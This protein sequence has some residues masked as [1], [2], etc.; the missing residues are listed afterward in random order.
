M[1]ILITGGVGYIGYS[2]TK[3]LLQSKNDIDEIVIYDNLSRKNYAFFSTEK[4]NSK[5]IKFIDGE[6]LDSKKLR[7]N[8]KGIDVVFHLAAKVTT[9]YADN[10]SHFF[11]QVNHW[12]TSEVVNAVEESNVKHFIHLSSISVYGSTEETVD[13]DYSPHPHSFYGISKYKA[14]EHVNRLSSKIKTHII[15]SGNVYGYNPAIRID[16]AINKFLFQANFTGRITINGNGTQTR[17]YIH[18]EK[19]SHLLSEIINTDMP[20]GTYNI[21]EHVFSIND[22]VFEIKELYPELEA[23]FVNQNMKMRQIKVHTPCKI[24]DYLKWNEKS[25]KEELI[26]FKEQFAF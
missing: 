12:G 13:E 10:E 26:E 22:V 23:L 18:L 20:T 8:L 11:D 1:K 2:L 17:A 9:P 15:R 3:Q 16:A 6:I 4:L 14:E 21:V 25:F 24:L 7:D 19:L 5:P